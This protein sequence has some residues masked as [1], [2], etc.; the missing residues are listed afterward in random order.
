MRVAPDGMAWITGGAFRRAARGAQSDQGRPISCAPSYCRRYRPAARY[1]QAV[2]TTARHIGFR[3]VLRSKQAER[4][5]A[6]LATFLSPA[7]A[8]NLT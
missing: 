2:D 6:G 7:K 1:P 3:C 5:D 8:P 4:T